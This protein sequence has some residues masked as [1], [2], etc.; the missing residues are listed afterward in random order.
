MASLESALLQLAATATSPGGSAQEVL[1]QVRTVV[2]LA[3]N[4]DPG[5]RDRLLNNFAE[6][7]AQVDGPR[8]SALVIGCG[9]LVESGGDPVVALLPTLQ[10]LPDLLGSAGAFYA[11]CAEQA[12]RAHDKGDNDEPNEEDEKKQKPSPIEEFGYE[13]SHR[14][15][16]EAMCWLSVEPM[17][18]G[19]ISMLSRTVEGRR[20]ARQHPDLLS[21][22]QGLAGVHGRAGF[23][24]RLLQV[25]DEEPLL[26]LHPESQRGYRVRFGG[27]AENFQLQTLL[28]AVLIGDPDRGW[29]PGT[30]P[31]PRVAAAARNRPVDPAAPTAVASF[32][33]WS[34]RGLQPDGALPDGIEGSEYW[35]W[36]E[37]V[38]VDI[39]AFEGLRVVLLGPPPYPRSWNAGR[40]FDGL[41]AN[42]TVEETLST[43]DVRSWLQ[44]IATAP[45]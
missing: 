4:V 23:L 18:M 36:N 24:A 40:C 32:N 43:P 2:N 21:R 45:R 31:D 35:V 8:A 16:S 27:I 44:R 1:G 9:S 20:V 39:P 10:Q 11:A 25:L 26:V 22:A 33:L 6:L 12:H 15:Q 3:E 5:T 7:I 37:G 19:A 28:A 14:M 42:L 34:W 41:H 30:P 13:L 38:P 17:C 29:L